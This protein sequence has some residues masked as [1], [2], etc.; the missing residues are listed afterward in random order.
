MRG[1]D[2]KAGQGERARVQGRAGREG[3]AGQGESA[4]QGRAR[5]QGRAGRECEAGQGESAR[6]GRARWRECK[7]GQEE[8]GQ[9]R[10]LAS[11]SRFLRRSHRLASCAADQFRE[12]TASCSSQ[13]SDSRGCR[14][15]HRTAGHSEGRW[16]IWSHTNQMNVCRDGPVC[17]SKSGGTASSPRRGQVT[18]PSSPELSRSPY[19]R[20][21][22]VRGLLAGDVSG[23]CRGRERK[24]CVRIRSRR[25][26]GC[27]EDSPAE[28][29]R[30]PGR[31]Y[32]VGPGTA[33]GPSR[34]NGTGS[35]ARPRTRRA[36]AP[37]GREGGGYPP[38]VGPSS[39]C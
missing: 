23:G 9:V 20:R 12:A 26:K 39:R 1:R 36:P 37:L 28:Q 8:A 6:Q 13:T 19:V 15:S 30:R 21:C 16:P 18:W 29:A 7:A 4:R 33:S 3:E 34:C 25:G 27:I 38:P 11:S 10:R 32:R 24:Q 5:V 2:C 35:R 17:Q 22:A 14:V 31:P